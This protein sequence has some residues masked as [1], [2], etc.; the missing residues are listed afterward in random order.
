MTIIEERH[1]GKVRRCNATC[2][3]ANKSKCACICGARYHGAGRM[4][5]EM[6]TD[7]WLGDDWR[8]HKAQIEA[9]G[10]SLTAVLSEAFQS[11]AQLTV[12]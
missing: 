10:G 2:H 5:Q 9:E 6:L 1:G 12:K 7:D 11:A 4:A 3:N 8:E